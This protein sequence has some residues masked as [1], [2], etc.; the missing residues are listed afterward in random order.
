MTEASS[1]VILRAVFLDRC[2]G[3]VQVCHEWLARECGCQR[4]LE[5]FHEASQ[6]S[7][8]QRGVRGE[9]WVGRRRSLPPRRN[10]PDVWPVGWLNTALFPG[11]RPRAWR[12]A[13]ER[14]TALTYERRQAVWRAAAGLSAARQAGQLFPAGCSA[15]RRHCPAGRSGRS[16]NAARQPVPAPRPGVR[17]WPA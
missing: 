3:S 16:R 15:Q 10:S 4:S 7:G 11:P 17:P 9:L 8:L 13:A 12:T 2:S 1:A 5:W 14:S 6:M